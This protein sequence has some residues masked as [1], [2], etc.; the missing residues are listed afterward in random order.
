VEHRTIV[1]AILKGDA[2][3][4]EEAW[5]DHLAQSETEA[6][7]HLRQLI[8]GMAARPE[9]KRRHI[10]RHQYLPALGRDSRAS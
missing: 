7:E 9:S 1:Q 10:R 2:D 4:T 6:V 3:A 8:P 5:R